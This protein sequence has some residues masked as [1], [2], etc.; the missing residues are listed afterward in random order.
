MRMIFA[1]VASLAFTAAAEAATFRLGTPPVAAITL[2][3]DWDTDEI[4]R[5]VEST[6][7][8]EEIYIAAEVASISKLEDAVTQAVAYLISEGVRIDQKTEKRS[9]GKIG[10]LDAFFIEYKGVDE[11]DAAT[12]VS[13][14]VIVASPTTAIIVTYWGSEEGEKANAAALTAIVNS[15]KKV[16]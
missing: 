9:E 15:I 8:D 1:V 13:V 10:G 4:D 5:G 11:D 7:K 3:D 12:E 16:D 2:P 6:S 14:G